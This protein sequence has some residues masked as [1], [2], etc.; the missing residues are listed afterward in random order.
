[1]WRSLAELGGACWGPAGSG[2]RGFATARGM[3]GLPHPFGSM[4]PE[5]RFY[6]ARWPT[7]NSTQPWVKVNTLLPHL[8]NIAIL[9]Q[10]PMKKIRH[11]G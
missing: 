1:M 10:K 2:G 6:S 3:P 8:K 9:K 7:E 5:V 4:R 11:T